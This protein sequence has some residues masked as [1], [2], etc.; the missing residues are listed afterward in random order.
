MPPNSL[1]DV[2]VG[3]INLGPLVMRI[4][5]AC[6]DA[7]ASVGRFQCLPKLNENNNKIAH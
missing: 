4:Q 5:Q 6:Q 7:V 2:A 1:H 3:L